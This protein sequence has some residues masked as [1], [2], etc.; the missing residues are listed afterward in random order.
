MRR[1]TIRFGNGKCIMFDWDFKFPLWIHRGFY[2]KRATEEMN[3][4]RDE[5]ND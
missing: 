4:L 3:K 1:F 5:L 2:G